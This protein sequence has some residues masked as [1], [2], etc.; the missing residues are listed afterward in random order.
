M[1]YQIQ[2]NLSGIKSLVELGMHGHFPLFP[3]N[4]I[5]NVSLNRFARI[6]KNE[7]EKAQKI[8]NRLAKHKS[9]DRKR[10]VLYSLSNSERDV[11]LKVFFKMVEGRILDKKTELH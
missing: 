10:T 1:D 5:E 2:N 3:N 9:L 7:K 4:W 8:I 11:F 6:T